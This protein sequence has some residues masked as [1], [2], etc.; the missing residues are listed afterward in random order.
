VTQ[1]PSQV[2]RERNLEICCEISKIWWLWV[3][4]NHRPIM[5]VQQMNVING[6]H[7]TA[8]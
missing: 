5:S 7:L 8:F 1:D 2:N 3:D 6:L 4:S